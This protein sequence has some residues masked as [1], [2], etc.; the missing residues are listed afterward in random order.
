MKNLLKTLPLLGLLLTTT[1]CEEGRALFRPSMFDSTSV[2]ERPIEIFEE[3][4]VEKKPAAEITPAYL[5]SLATDYDHHGASPIYMVLGYNPDVKNAKLSTFN[6]S[7]I[8]KG[9][10][11]K[12]GLTNMIVK[13]MPVIG[14]TGDVVI[15]YDRVKARGPQDCG[16]MPGMETETG[17]YGDYGLGCTVKD[18]MAQQIAYPADLKG[19]SNM[20]E[21]DAGRAA[22][23]VNRDARSGE[24]ADF[25]PSYVLSELAANTTN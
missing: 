25:V 7:N 17:A 12:L 4:F 15:G 22:A 5:N 23:P 2:T 10:L 21:F 16:K 24:V 3:R 13:T 18:M 1:A 11:A 6:K 19:Q 9:Q 20:D 8:L 14:S